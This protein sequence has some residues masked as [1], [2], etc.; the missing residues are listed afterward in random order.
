MQPNKFQRFASLLV[1]ALLPAA[2][3]IKA[4]SLRVDTMQIN[5]LVAEAIEDLAQ[6]ES[7]SPDDIELASIEEVIWPDTSMGCPHPDMRYRQVPQ[8]GL[9]IILRANGRQYSYHSGG[10]RSPFLCK[11]KGVQRATGRIEQAPDTDGMDK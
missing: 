2:L 4:E 8:D 5:P 7:I 11:L 6:Q 3:P 1:I 9:R 10:N